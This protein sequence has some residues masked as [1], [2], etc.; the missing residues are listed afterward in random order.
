LSLLQNAKVL[1]K[2]MTEAERILWQQLRAKRF[3]GFKFKRQQPF[4]RYIVDFVCFDAKLIIEL[5]GGQHQDA[6]E[7][8]AARD[9]W[10]KLQ[11]F[12]VLRFWNNEFLQN[13]TGCLERILAE[14][15][16]TTLSLN[17]SPLKG[18]GS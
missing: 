2:N 1:R 9:A 12:S 10:L 15:D 4:G 14:L 18:E 5:D 8:D 17:P 13:Q 16:V 7:Q 6:A 11:G 3:T